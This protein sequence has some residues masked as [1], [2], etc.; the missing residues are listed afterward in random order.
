MKRF[1][2]S[3]LAVVA[4]L[5]IGLTAFTKAEPAK[6][7]RETIPNCYSSLTATTCPTNFALTANSTSCA[8]ALAQDERAVRSIG[9]F[10]A[11]I[12]CD[13]VQ[14]VFCCAQLVAVTDPICVGQPQLTFRDKNNVQQI[15]QFAKIDAVFCKAQL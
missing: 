1:N 2:V 15:N 6:G 13:L 14:Q 5:A 11:S 10:N 4:V 3:I 8:S 7:K 12:T 9:T